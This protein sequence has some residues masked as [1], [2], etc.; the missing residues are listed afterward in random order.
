MPCLKHICGVGTHKFT[1]LME[2]HLFAIRTPHR[3]RNYPA[4]CE[5]RHHDF[6]QMWLS[7][8]MPNAL[9]SHS[10]LNDSATEG[11]NPPRRFSTRNEIGVTL[12]PPPM[13]HQRWVGADG[14]N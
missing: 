12:G 2:H 8:P 6:D 11:L 7:G 3:C 1:A 4:P 13:G 14:L 9:R 5:R 10:V